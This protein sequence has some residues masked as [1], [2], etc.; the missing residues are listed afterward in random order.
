MLRIK[1]FSWASFFIGSGA[2]FVLGALLLGIVVNYLVS[3]A[4]SGASTNGVFL[5]SSIDQVRAGIVQ[6]N[7]EQEATSVYGK[8]VSIDHASGTFVLEVMQSTG[9]KE[10]TFTYDNSTKIV[11]L[12]NDAASTEI[13]L[14]SDEI[15]VGTGLTVETSEAVG[16]VDNQ[17]AVK[18]TR[19]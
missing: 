11:Y 8:V 9:K 3:Q 12:A 4:I 10:F 1:N 6:V 15:T 19:L 13:P 7:A 2:G 17:H 14:S 18:V 5:G 16:S